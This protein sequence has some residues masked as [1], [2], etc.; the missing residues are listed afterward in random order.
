MQDDGG[1]EEE[2]RRQ[3]RERA[4]MSA[5]DRLYGKPADGLHGLKRRGRKAQMPLYMQL[6]VRAIVE[7]I[8]QRD[9]HDGLPSLFEIM[10]QLYLDK[11]GGIDGSLIPSDDELVDRYL[12]KQDKNDAK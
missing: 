11:Y 12:R 10:L 9:H 4:K 6:K 2:R 8:M 3:A 1:E 7:A 5:F